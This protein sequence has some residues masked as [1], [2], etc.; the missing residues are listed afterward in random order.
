MNYTEQ[1]VKLLRNIDKSPN[2][3]RTDENFSESDIRLIKELKEEK[4]LSGNCTPTN[5]LPITNIRLTVKG[6]TFLEELEQK[7]REQTKTPRVLNL[8]LLLPLLITA[9]I[10]IAGWWFVNYLESCRDIENKK[11]E[12]KTEYLIN[13]YRTIAMNA[14]RSPAKIVNFEMPEDLKERMFKFELAI[15]D[16]QLFGTLPQIELL[17]NFVLNKPVEVVQANPNEWRIISKDVNKLLTDLRIELREV[18]NL[19]EIPHPEEGVYWF[20]LERT[21][22]A[23]KKKNEDKQGQGDWNKRDRH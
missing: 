11:L 13:A 1:C 4:Y 2:P 18:L 15:A 8:S 14:G 23:L 9:I 21:L 12:I 22:R 6:H 20:R 10:T 3:A 17:K 19:E 7:L 5:T 16:I